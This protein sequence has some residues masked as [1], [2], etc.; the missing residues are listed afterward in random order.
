MYDNEHVIDLDRDFKR[1]FLREYWEQCDEHDDNQPDVCACGWIAR[2][3]H[4]RPFVVG[5][6]NP[7]GTPRRG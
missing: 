5:S 4:S 6:R 1:D 3:T 2:H 7:D